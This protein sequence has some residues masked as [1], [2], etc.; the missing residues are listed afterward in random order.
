[1]PGEQVRANDSVVL[2]LATLKEIEKN[3]EVV[4]SA[5]DGDM[6]GR[7]DIAEALAFIQTAIKTLSR[8]AAR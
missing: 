5:R 3:L 8:S 1:M 7:A 6:A 4:L 2:E